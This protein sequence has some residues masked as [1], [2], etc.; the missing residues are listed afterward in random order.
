MD[1]LGAMRAFAQV[2][3]SGSFTRAADAL[4]LHKA[5]VT[6]RVQ[7]LERELQVRLFSRTTRRVVAT[8]EAMVLYP[9]VCA[10]LQQLDEA[11]AGVRKGAAQPSGRLRVDVP[12]ALGR[13]VLVPEIGS[14]LERFP[15]L[16]LEL[17]C[18]DR[19]VNLLEEGVDCA[20]RGGEMPD[21]TLVGRRIGEVPFVLCASPRYIERHGLPHDPQQLGEH[22]CVGYL[23]AASRKARD[24]SLTR[25]G[26][27]IDVPIAPRFA[28]NDSGAVLSAGLDG[29]GIVQIAEFVARH[30]LA[31]GALIEVL[32][33][34]CCAALPLYLLTPPSRQ[35]ATRVQVFMEWAE[36]VIRRKLARPVAARQT[37]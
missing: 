5:T 27:L 30:H 28:T 37:D 17:G 31:S 7:Q 35:R 1:R 32:P 3:D 23:A 14:F 10:I 16:S 15:R 12:V 6:Q 2:V 11:E 13:L 25:D 36:A 20:L 8:P 9:R 24:V 22:E 21:S 34:W 33:A 19:A 18:T 4:K 29:V 26:T